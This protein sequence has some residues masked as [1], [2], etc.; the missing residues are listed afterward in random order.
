M[1]ISRPCQPEKLIPL[2]PWPGFDPSFSGHNDRRA[3]ISEWTWLRLRPLSHR[4]WLSLLV[5]DSMLNNYFWHFRSA[6]LAWM[7]T[8]AENDYISVH[9]LYFCP[10]LTSLSVPSHRPFVP[11]HRC[12]WLYCM[13]AFNTTLCSENIQIMS[14]SSHQGRPIW[15]LGLC[16]GGGVRVLTLE[17]FFLFSWGWSTFFFAARSTFFKVNYMYILQDAIY[18]Y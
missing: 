18:Y 2:L 17:F 8:A 13:N 10:Y 12:E 11:S 5:Q 4:G 14:V 3:I 9:K 15:F 1:D 6:S 7:I 16:R